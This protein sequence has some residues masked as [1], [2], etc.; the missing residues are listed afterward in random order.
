ETHQLYMQKLDEVS[1]LQ[2]SFSA[3]IS[4][5]RKCIK[6]MSRSLKTV[7]KGLTEEETKR[8]EKMKG[9]L[10]ERPAIFLQMETFLPKK[11]GLYLSLVLGNVNVNLLSKQSK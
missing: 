3:S 11:N 1:K 2:N 10:Q 7:S 4:R 8:V 6:D 9:C 5:Q